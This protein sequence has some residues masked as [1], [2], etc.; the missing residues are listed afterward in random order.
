LDNGFAMLAEIST[1]LHCPAERVWQEVQTSRLL[2][3]V[4]QPLLTFQPIEPAALPAVWVEGSYLVRMRLF[5]FIPLGTQSIVIKHP[6]VDPAKP[7]IYRILDD[8]HGQLIARWHHL[9]TIC[10]MADGRTYYTDRVEVRAGLLTP[11]IWL[12]ANIF[13]RYRQSRWRRLVAL[14]FDYSV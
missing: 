12:S 14:N 4:T 8:G 5:G 3:Y 11:L 9:I 10:A 2:R 13:Y 1:V 7:G 6:T